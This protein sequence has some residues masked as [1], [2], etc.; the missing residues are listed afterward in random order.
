MLSASPPSVLKIFISYSRRDLQIANSFVDELKAKNF[1]VF[2]DKR[3]LQYGEQWQNQLAESIRSSDTVV[4]LISEASVASRW[5][6]WELGEVE[7]LK[8]RLVPVRIANVD[9]DA[10][11][12]SLGK[13]H[14]LPSDEVFDFSRHFLSLVDAL[15]TDAAW[16]RE[17]TRLLDRAGQWKAKD[18]DEAQLL[19]GRALS[20]AE[21]WVSTK[22]AAA[23]AINSEILDLLLHSRQGVS[24]RQKR[25]VL[26]S[27]LVAALGIGLAV[28]AWLERNSALASQSTYLSKL[29]AENVTNGDAVT[30]ALLAMSAL[31]T[32]PY[33][34]DRPLV[35]EA[36]R[37]LHDAMFSMREM[38]VLEGHTADVNTAVFSA[39][40]KL[41]LT[42]SDDG[43]AR[44]WR[45][46]LGSSFEPSENTPAKYFPQSS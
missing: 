27:L 36:E 11:P 19:G 16:L 45:A 24:R 21:G 34:L 33:A 18:Q 2:I 9:P 22:P 28:Y 13:I 14:A 12:E 32:W 8:K 26:L 37:S 29:S 6:K 20:D 10:L 30:G 31:P 4:W 43:T 38:R 1:E 23:P 3:G 46:D 17:A 5:V 7:R 25:T 42:A 35:P 41:I 40:D 15:K 44:L 39:D